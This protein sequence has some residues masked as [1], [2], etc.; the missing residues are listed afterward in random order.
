MTMVYVT[1]GARNA[2]AGATLITPAL[3]TITGR[4]L[5]ALLAV[6]SIKSNATIT[7][8]Q[9]GW[10]KLY[11][12]N[13]GA[14]FTTA[15]FIAPVGSGAPGCTWTGSVAAGAQCFYIED[16]DNP[17]VTNAVG[18]TSSNSGSTAA[19]SSSSITTTRQRSLAAYIDTTSSNSSLPAPTNWTED[20]EAGSAT[21]GITI[22][23]GTRYIATLGG[24]TGAISVTGAAVDWVQR[25]IE[26]LIVDPAAGVQ[27]TESE[28]NPLLSAG[29]GI[30]AAD[31]EIAP[32]ISSGV[33]IG[34]ADMEIVALLGPGPYIPRRRTVQIHQ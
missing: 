25:Q 16:A 29:D 10:T 28:I 33:G 19:H 14:S 34:V 26:F 6:V 5:G 32:L 24:T 20:S 22:T 30:S 17:M 8:A 13:S 9:P 3:P 23:L 4:D 21:D 15:Y 7:T 27:V 18:A 1:S 31:V 2:S 11:Q 12:D